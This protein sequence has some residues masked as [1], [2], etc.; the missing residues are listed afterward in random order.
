MDGL[1]SPSTRPRLH[2]ITHPVILLAQ[3]GAGRDG[4]RQYARRAGPE[5]G[6]GDNLARRA[7]RAPS[8]LGRPRRGS[9]SCDRGRHRVAHSAPPETLE[10]TGRRDRRGLV[11]RRRARQSQYPKT[12]KS[13]VMCRVAGC[14]KRGSG[15]CTTSWPGP[16]PTPDAPSRA[17]CS[18]QRVTTAPEAPEKSWTSGAASTAPSAPDPG[19]FSH[20]RGSGIGFLNQDRSQFG[21]AGLRRWQ[22]GNGS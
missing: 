6:M 4:F 3:C 11:V 5:T 15:D 2:D 17:S 10:V 22:G 7:R 21:D 16:A 19:P 9:Q 8:R 20:S 14:P 12:G 18:P 13:G 1:R